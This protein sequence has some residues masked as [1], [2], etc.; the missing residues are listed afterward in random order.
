MHVWPVLMSAWLC[1]TNEPRF[2]LGVVDAACASAVSVSV[3]SWM[4]VR[5]YGFC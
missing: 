3:L 4:R 2:C 5:N 1:S